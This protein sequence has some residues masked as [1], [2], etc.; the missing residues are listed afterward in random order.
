MLPSKATPTNTQTHAENHPHLAYSPLSISGLHISQAGFGCYRVEIG[1]EA[2]YQALRYALQHGINLIDTSPNYGDGRSEQLIGQLL[3]RMVASGELKREEVVVVSKAGYIQGQN[4][5]IANQRKQTG[6][7]FPNVVMYDDQLEHCIHPDF[8]QDQLTRSLERLGLETIDVYLLH[9]PE[10]YLSWANRVGIALPEARRAYYQRI[11]LAFKHL[12][13]EVQNGR[14]QW[15]GISSNTFPRPSR[16]P[17]FTSLEKVW[18]IAQNLGNH[19][20]RVI[21]LPMNLWETGAI[22]EKNLWPQTTLEFARQKEIAVLVNRPLNALREN[23]FMRLADTLSMPS[24][25]TSVEEVSTA[26]DTLVEMELDF[27]HT[28]AP[29]LKLDDPQTGR[30]VLELLAIGQVLQGHWRGFGTY[31]NWRDLQAQYLVPRAQGGVQF[32]SD[33]PNLP[34]A[35]SL[36]LDS[37]VDKVNEVLAAVGAFYQ[38]QTI[39]QAHQIRQAAAQADPDW[40]TNHLSQ[41]AVRVL[42]ST[43]G[44]SCVLVGM[45]QVAYV[46]D[47]LAELG[48]PIL[49]KERTTAWKTFENGSKG[50]TP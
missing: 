12:E 21:Q 2:H 26:V 9:N 17:E 20:F 27:Q 43:A 47:I 48:R 40:H 29:H 49:L 11:E 1:T 3:D 32:L 28:I 35:T 6:R 19:H 24:Y 39:K 14:I 41:T 37:Y 8:L 50:G 13:T 31:Y 45:R 38:E 15:Y 34:A 25:P 33:R 44:V 42:R 4:L 5:E 18:D 22:T 30:R 23:A 7:P 36:W 10:Y 46:Q 16:D